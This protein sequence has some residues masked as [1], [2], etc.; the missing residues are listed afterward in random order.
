VKLRACVTLA[1]C[2]ALT[3]SPSIRTGNDFLPQL[4]YLDIAD[5]ALDKMFEIYKEIMPKVD[6]YLTHEGEINWKR[7]EVFLSHLAKYEQDM[8]SVMP[9]LHLDVLEQS[10]LNSS[11]S[12]G[13]EGD[14]DEEGEIG[15]GGIGGPR[16]GGWQKRKGKEPVGTLGEA[17]GAS[18]QVATTTSSSS[19]D[20]STSPSSASSSTTSS[21]TEATNSTSSAV[22]EDA[23]A[24]LSAATLKKAEKG[25]ASE[26]EDDD[27]EDDSWKNW[28]Y[29]DKFR[30]GLENQEFPSLVEEVL[31]RGSRLGAQVLLLRLLLVELVLPAP[32]CPA[33]FR[34]V[35]L[36]NNRV[37]N[38]WFAIRSGGSAFVRTQVRSGN[39]VPSVPAAD[40]CAPTGQPQAAASLLP[41]ADDERHVAHP[42]LLSG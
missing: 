26:E 41:G 14:E 3:V 36:V 29:R 33:L 22:P 31:S 23:L 18:S 24:A 9:P 19:S 28:Y 25:K 4:P 5:G 1:F 21:S 27:E 32:L 30:V 34:Y 11:G 40:G 2:N 39:S 6:G 42:R 12:E 10:V 38:L 37:S 8:M 13:E 16:A 15:G 20:S 7:T 35:K 17:A